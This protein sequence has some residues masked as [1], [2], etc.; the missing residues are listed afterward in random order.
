MVG[1]GLARWKSI[2]LRAVHDKNV[3]PAIV[4]IIENGNASPGGFSDVFFCVLPAEDI[5]HGETGF[6][7]F[8]VEVRDGVGAFGVLVGGTANGE[9]QR[10]EK[11]GISAL[12]KGDLASAKAAFENV[13]RMAP[14]SAEGHNSLGWVF[15]AQEQIDAAIRQFQAA[16]R[17]KPDFAQAHINLANAFLRKADTQG[18]LRESREATRVAPEDSEAHRTLA[19]ALDFSQDVASATHEMRRA[20]AFE[21]NSAV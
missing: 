9:K 2:E 14:N 20:T 10:K 3:R 17:L 12:Q 1:R 15:L 6:F 8:V 18:A 7:G 4:V 21:P 19:R 16:V 13:G 11:K 5:H